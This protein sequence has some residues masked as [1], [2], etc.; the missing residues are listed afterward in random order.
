MKNKQHYLSNFNCT[1][2]LKV[3]TAMLTCCMLWS[4]GL[5]AQTFQ[6]VVFGNGIA[7]DAYVAGMVV[8]SAANPQKLDGYIAVGHTNSYAIGTQQNIWVTRFD[9]TGNVLWSRPIAHIDLDDFILQA[10]DVQAASNNFVDNIYFPDYNSIRSLGI[11]AGE[12]TICTTKSSF[13]ISGFYVKKGSALR[14]MLLIKLDDQANVIWTLT[15]FANYLRRDYD[16][17][18]VSVEVSD[19]DGDVFVTG[20]ASRGVLDKHFIVARVN[21]NG[22]L[23]WCNRYL[24]DDPCNSAGQNFELIP[25]QSCLYK[26]PLGHTGIAVIGGTHYPLA[27]I[28]DYAFVSRINADG[29]E[30]WRMTSYS[31]NNPDGEP[32]MGN[33][34]IV[35]KETLAYTFA[36]TGTVTG[37]GKTSIYNFKVD[38]AGMQTAGQK[39][40]HPQHSLSGQSIRTDAGAGPDYVITGRYTKS[41][42]QYVLLLKTK[43]N[44]N[45]SWSWVYTTYPRT[46]VKGTERGYSTGD[47]YFIT[48]NT[49]HPFGNTSSGHVLATNGNGKIVP[50]ECAHTPVLLSQ[51][52]HGEYFELNRVVVPD[53]VVRESKSFGK[54]FPPRYELCTEAPM[55]TEAGFN[56]TRDVLSIFPNPASQSLNVVL[57]SAVSGQT[58]LE[59][60]GMDGG[61]V[62]TK[63]MSLVPGKNALNWNIS[64]LKPGNYM[65]KA[66]QPN[67]Q[68]LRRHWVKQ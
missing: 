57:Q 35:A 54:T 11:T 9:A 63:T 56:N 2:R 14:K 67:G 44:A 17:A 41:P 53:P 68:S 36:A 18:A 62:E 31:G 22:R 43:M 4:P 15:D 49:D 20:S 3:L 32:I 19:R 61:L 25:Q 58:Q 48:T 51:A 16:E 27:K 45:P 1:G 29:T 8:Y 50:D 47:G 55:R 40:S 12:G 60:Y 28:I 7:N 59:L 46:N 5:R 38:A 65:L 23:L 34:I 10:S 21:A 30:A 39:I 26:D 6:N 13:Y 66:S 24:A 64:R 52:A 42:D 37:A 33:D